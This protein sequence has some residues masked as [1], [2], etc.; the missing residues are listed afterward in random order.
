LKPQLRAE[1]IIQRIKAVQCQFLVQCSDDESFYR[2]PGGSV[3][4]GE[5]SVQTLERELFEEYSLNIDVGKLKVVSERLISFNGIDL[6]QITL[7]HFAKLIDDGF[8]LLR[9]KEHSD[10]KIVWRTFEE[11]CSKPVFPPGILEILTDS[12]DTVLHLINGFND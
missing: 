7:L 10:V 1:S 9:H 12:S 6:H 3:E 4:F 5:T 2:F 11:L 8:T